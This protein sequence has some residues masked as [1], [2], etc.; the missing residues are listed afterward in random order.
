MLL[1]GL[2]G[3]ENK[4]HPGEAMDKDIYELPPEELKEI[5]K[6]PGSLEE[7][8][9][10]LKKDYAFLLK[11]DVFAKEVIETWI[12]WKEENEIKPAR[13]RPTPFEFAQYF[14]A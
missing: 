13:L 6:A 2:D 5:P 7:A 8:I 14:D 9:N 11:G 10:S 12:N 1:A 3:V 4:I